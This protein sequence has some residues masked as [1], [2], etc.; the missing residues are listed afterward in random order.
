MTDPVPAAFLERPD[1]NR[2]A[3]VRRGGEGPGVVWL[4][5]FR[6]D[7]EGGKALALDA[8]CSEAGRAFVRFDYFAHG[9]SSGE[10]DVATVGRWR[11]DALAVIDALTT[12]PQVLVGSSMGGW[13]ALLA[14]LARPDRV[15]AL[16]LIAPA[17]D[18]T[19]ALFWEAAP[20]H[21]REA[22]LKDGFWDAPSA[23][24]GAVRY[25]RELVEEARNWLLLDKPVPF[26]GPVRILQGWRDQDVPW[27]HAVKL[28]EALESED[29][30][31][32]L[33]K[34][35]DHRLSEPDD[36]ARLIAAVGA[37]CA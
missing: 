29:A 17:P 20:M 3:Y 1:G 34:D 21:V 28:Y 14:A 35:G 15:K 13:I 11:E 36:I 24:G 6:S 16:V 27:S 7:M 19:E 8:A 32:T 30:E 2:L 31:L 10:W 33:I 5:G 26:A 12:G 9:R 25:T 18:F 4:G 22:I 23:Y 37:A